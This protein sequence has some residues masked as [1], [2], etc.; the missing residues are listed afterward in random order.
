[1]LTRA[2]RAGWWCGGIVWGKR[3]L[4]V[5]KTAQPK[6]LPVKNTILMLAVLSFSVAACTA[7]SDDT[8]EDVFTDEA[9]QR[10][11]PT[12]PVPEPARQGAPAT[13]RPSAAA[14]V[15]AYQAVV[16]AQ[17]AAVASIAGKTCES[18]AACDTG[19]PAFSGTCN[20][21]VWTG[22][23]GVCLVGSAPAPRFTCADFSCPA[24]FQ[25]EVEASTGAVGCVESRT[26]IPAGANGGGGG[27]GRNR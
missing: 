14:K 9:A 20:R 4:A 26:C 22:T 13:A 2:V 5:T 15:A 24:K 17:D 25:C 19:N 27:G 7:S 10:A 23:N 12:C 6:E 8:S 18:D 1:M 3:F 21:Y 16:A 11:K